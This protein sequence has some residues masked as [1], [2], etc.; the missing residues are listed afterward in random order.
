MTPKTT[1]S[2]TKNFFIGDFSGVRVG[3]EE[4]NATGQRVASAAWR[5]RRLGGGLVSEK[6]LYLKGRQIPGAYFGELMVT[7]RS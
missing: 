1:S 6:P 4:S 5:V 3:T 2:R 7:V